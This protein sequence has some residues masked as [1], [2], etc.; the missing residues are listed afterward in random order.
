MKKFCFIILLCSH[1]LLAQETTFKTNYSIELDPIA[2]VLKGYSFH[3]IIQPSSHISFD[4]GIFGIEEPEGF[5]GND[6]FKIRQNGFG[7][8]ANYHFLEGTTRG[9]Y[10]GLNIGY[11]TVYATHNTSLAVAN[12]NNIT[13]GAQMGYRFSFINRKKVFK[14]GYTLFLGLATATSCIRKQ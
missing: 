7:I 2:Y 13:I 14:S 8:K 5:S 3:G 9:L 11:A 6:G 4:L 10:T 1:Q 12:G